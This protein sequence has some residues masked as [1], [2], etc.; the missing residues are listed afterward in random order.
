MDI[1]GVRLS[2]E[3]IAHFHDDGLLIVDRLIDPALA[4]KA[5]APFEPLFKREFETGIIPD[6]VSWGGGKAGASHYTGHTILRAIALLSLALSLTF[7]AMNARA[8]AL[9]ST[10]EMTGRAIVEAP[11]DMVRIELAARSEA[12]NACVA[13]AADADLADRL[14]AALH[15]LGV[16]E[17]DIETS[18]FRFAT[19][20]Q[21]DNPMAN[22]PGEVEV[23]L[24]DPDPAPARS[25]EGGEPT[26][27]CGPPE[28]Y[29]VDST[30]I[31]TLR[32]FDAL[33]AALAQLGRLDGI[34]VLGLRRSLTETSELFAR[35]RRAALE[36]AEG[37]AAAYAAARALHL[38]GPFDVVP[39]PVRLVSPT[40]TPDANGALR[41]A[42]EASI[43]LSYKV[44]WD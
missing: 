25:G 36:N 13:L 39:G 33:G 21:P 28:S 23:A 29:R 9:T 16:T 10:L 11:A 12:T 37:A 34:E 26:V 15:D 18:D 41:V 38:S 19:T 32:R 3:Q 14:A 2:N 6:S 17:S 1:D 27:A 40:P 8:Q 4:A 43:T 20:K 42:A 22:P 31:V 35:A 5:A 7:G 24:L 30:V 44:S